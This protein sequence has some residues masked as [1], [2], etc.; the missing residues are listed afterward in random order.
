MYNHDF[1]IDDKT[2]ELVDK[3]KNLKKN[4]AKGSVIPGFFK[5]VRSK[6]I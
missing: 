2:L 6:V 3:K 1:D 4:S 5:F